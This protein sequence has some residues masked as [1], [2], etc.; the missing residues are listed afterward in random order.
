[1]VA[2]TMGLGLLEAPWWG[3]CCCKAE[4]NFKRTASPGSSRR[5]AV[6][7]AETEVVAAVA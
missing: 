6:E 4:M 1:M 5:V 2:A 3:V 7:Q